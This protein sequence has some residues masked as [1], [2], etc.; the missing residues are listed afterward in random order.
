MI[1]QIETAFDLNERNVKPCCQE[2]VD[3]FEMV[4]CFSNER[5]IIELCLGPYLPD[6]GY[7]TTQIIA[8]PQ[9]QTCRDGAKRTV[10]CHVVWLHCREPLDADFAASDTLCHCLGMFGQF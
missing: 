7:K 1:C 9:H 5:H 8:H 3:G 4:S 10:C 6:V 2:I